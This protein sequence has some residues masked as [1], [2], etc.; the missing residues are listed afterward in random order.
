[1]PAT[2]REIDG[3]WLEFSVSG[4]ANK[5]TGGN[6][7]VRYVEIAN[8]SAN[9]AT[10]E[11]HKLDSGGLNDTQ[12]VSQTVPANTR[13]GVAV[14]A[15]PFDELYAVGVSGAEINMIVTIDPR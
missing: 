10:V 12:L 13:V 1:M 11:L 9:S 6:Y 4:A 8:N 7:V 3:L 15:G 5:L 14:N 2:N